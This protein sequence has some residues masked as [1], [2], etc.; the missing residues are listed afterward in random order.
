MAALEGDRSSH[1]SRS[2]RT[3]QHTA[4]SRLMPRRRSEPLGNPA[5]RMPRVVEET[6]GLGL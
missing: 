1:W 5:C 4:V 3:G 2:F 6:L